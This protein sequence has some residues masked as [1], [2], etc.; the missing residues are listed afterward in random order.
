V[1]VGRGGVA[2]R[3]ER[4]MITSMSSAGSDVYVCVCSRVLEL[5]FD[6]L[7]EGGGERSRLVR[8]VR[9][10]WYFAARVR[11]ILRACIGNSC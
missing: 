6:E 7:D 10:R 3:A 5:R 1:D 4:R 2:R 11:A 9:M 8:V